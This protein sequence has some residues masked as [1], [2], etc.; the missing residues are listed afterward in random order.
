MY[1]NAAGYPPV[2][3]GQVAGRPVVVPSGSMLRIRINQGLSTHHAQ[4]GS[5]FD[6]TVLN[7]VI[8]DGA[9]AIPRG[10]A[11]QG[12]VVEVKDAGVLK[13]RGEL[14]LQLTR[15]TLGG[16]SY[17]L[18]SDTWKRDGQDKSLHTVNSAIGLGALGALFGAVAGGGEGAAIGA[19]VGGAAGVASSA[20]SPG[21]SVIIPPEAVLTFHL[22]QPTPVTTVSEQEMGRLSYAAGPNVGP[23]PVVRRRYPDVYYAPYP[24][25]SPY[26]YP[27][28]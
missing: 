26:Y 14:A 25:Y 19:G 4:P 7:D 10:A 12:T 15:L 18:A 2:P 23:Q 13:G 27:R 22:Q 5:I 16:Q 3:G 8:A 11:V 20:A 9:V 21:G 28:Y 17:A 24:P 6:G 1:G